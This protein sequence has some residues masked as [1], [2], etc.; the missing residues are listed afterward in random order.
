MSNEHASLENLKQP[1]QM[2][3]QTLGI[4]MNENWAPYFAMRGACVGV[5]ASRWK[6]LGMDLLRID[7]S[8]V[9][10]KTDVTIYNCIEKVI[11]ANKRG[12]VV[13]CVDGLKIVDRIAIN[14]IVRLARRAA[15]NINA[16][17]MVVGNCATIS[18]ETALKLGEE[19]HVHFSYETFLGRHSDGLVEAKLI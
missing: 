8:G 9:I 4:K 3:N 6:M 1:L 15:S 17:H 5:A 19:F 16:V 11:M 14:M 10:N 18:K 13:I 2:A 7:F 12:I